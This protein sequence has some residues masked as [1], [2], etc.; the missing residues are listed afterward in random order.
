MPV[1]MTS[2]ISILLALAIGTW[3]SCLIR[4]CASAAQPVGYKFDSR[5]RQFTRIDFSRFDYIIV[6]DNENYRAITSMARTAEEREKVVMLTT[7]LQK[8]KGA[9]T[10]PDPYYGDDKDFDKALDLIED[11]CMGLMEEL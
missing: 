6:M 3:V 1:V 5:C 7:Y 10:V 11:A 4:V 2:L 8:Y 9:E